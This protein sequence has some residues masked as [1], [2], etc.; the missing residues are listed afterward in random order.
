M[1]ILEDKFTY[2]KE[3][4]HWISNKTFLGLSTG[5]DS[6]LIVDLWNEYT[7]I[8]HKAKDGT[9]IIT[10][11]SPRGLKNEEELITVLDLLD[12]KI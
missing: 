6:K 1:K 8:Y 11:D 7:T 2:D 12:I 9:D 5:D 3:N 4:M 10:F